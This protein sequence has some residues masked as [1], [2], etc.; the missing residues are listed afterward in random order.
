MACSNFEL[1]L[2]QSLTHS[3]GMLGRE[4]D[5]SL[6]NTRYTGQSSKCF[7]VFITLIFSVVY[8][9]VSGSNAPRLTN[10]NLRIMATVM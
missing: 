6:D 7:F 2:K 5:P 9:N 8:D 10:I 4:I 1:I 3:A